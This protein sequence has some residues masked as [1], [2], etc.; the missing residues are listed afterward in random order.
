[1]KKTLMIITAFLLT[2]ATLA[3]AQTGPRI[4]LFV[5]AGGS[6][7]ALRDV[8]PGEVQVHMLLLG[9]A[10]VGAVQFK[11]PRPDCWT[12]ATWVGDNIPWTLFI[13]NT[14]ATD[15]WGLSIAFLAD[16]DCAAANSPIYLAM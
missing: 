6:D 11:A 12:N 4:Q 9:A 14:Q 13:G 3:S 16:V 5:D 8:G 2:L 7:C 10:G 15:P 1:M